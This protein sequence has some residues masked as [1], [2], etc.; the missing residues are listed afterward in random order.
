MLEFGNSNSTENQASGA[1]VF[2]AS[3][4]DFMQ[5]VIEASQTTPVIVDFWAPWC[6]PCK[7]LV[8]LLEEAVN[9][10]KGAIKLAKVNVDENQMIA[11]Q[12]RVQSIPTVYAFFQGQPLDA[13]Q[14]ALPKSELETWIDG[15]IE[16][17]GGDPS[18]G[19]DDAL[20]SAEELLEQGA[21]VD[22]T[23]IFAAIL[24]EDPN[25][26]GAYSGLARAQL[27]MGDI[28][29]AEAILNGAP[30]EISSA[31]EIEMAYAKI[32]LARQAQ[33][34]GPLAELRQQSQNDPNNIALMV[35][36]ATALH[37]AGETQEAVDTLLAAFKKDRDWNEGAIKEQLFTIFNA[38][39]PQDPVVLKGRRQLSSLIFA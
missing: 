9:A 33:N 18:G 3:E 19:L 25:H 27:A 38:L 14:G 24:G 23:E 2:D 1:H 34:A 15:V 11:S 13:F 37:A 10:R 20:A 22:A 17:T 8:P 32:D 12:L 6:G 28:D 4:A 21:V 7:T 35:E 29:Q 26:A 39:P 30:A 16:K 31:K 5:T 36:L